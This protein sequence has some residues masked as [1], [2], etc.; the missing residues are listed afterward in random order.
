MTELWPIPVVL[1]IEDERQIRRFVRTALEKEGWVVNEAA[2]MREGHG[3]LRCNR[4]N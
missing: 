3:A 4:A 1:L 2:T